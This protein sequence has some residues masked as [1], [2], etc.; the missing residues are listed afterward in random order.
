MLEG[1]MRRHRTCSADS[2]I[3][4]FTRSSS[5]IYKRASHRISGALCSETDHV[6]TEFLFST[7]KSASA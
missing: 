5:C 3:V 6:V 1:L 4:D 7:M 2:G